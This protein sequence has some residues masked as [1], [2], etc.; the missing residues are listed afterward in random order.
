MKQ[1]EETGSVMLCSINW[2]VILQVFIL[3]LSLKLG[4]NSAYSLLYIYFI[5]LRMLQQSG[6]VIKHIDSGIQD[7]LGSFFQF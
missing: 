4:M 5:N 7:C 1:K 2:V 6:I 3:L